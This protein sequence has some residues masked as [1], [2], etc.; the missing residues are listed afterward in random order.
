MDIAGSVLEFIGTV[1]IAYTAIR[2][3]YRFWKAHSLSDKVFH[4][5]RREQIVGVSGVIF[6][7]IGFLLQLIVK[8]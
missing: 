8:L 3:H 4:E 1:M 6:I 2:V 7:T 5:M